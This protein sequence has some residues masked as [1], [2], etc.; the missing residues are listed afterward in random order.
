MS[1]SL[2]IAGVLGVV[3]VVIGSYAAHG[4]EV[5]LQ[6]QDLLADVIAKRMSQCDVAVRY[7]MMHTLA[8]LAI[9]LSGLRS[10]MVSS[11]V[12]FWLLGIALFSGGLYSMVFL[13]KTGHWAI[14]PSGGLCFIIGWALLIG[15]GLVA[16]S[17]DSKAD[18]GL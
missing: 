13:G 12:T 15:I 1:K 7:H 8:I 4:L 14:V 9:G 2:I 17:K 18:A 10:R 5:F 3:G 11:A 16:K 6:K